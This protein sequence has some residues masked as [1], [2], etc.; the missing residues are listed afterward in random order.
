MR[1]VIHSLASPLW[2]LNHN[3]N[4]QSLM[5]DM[6]LFLYALKGLIR[7]HSAVAVVTVPSHLYQEVI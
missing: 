4:V 7:Y 5:K 2:F 1:I 3:S 6:N